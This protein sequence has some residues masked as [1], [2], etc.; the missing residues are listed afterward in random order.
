MHPVFGSWFLVIQL[1]GSAGQRADTWVRPYTVMAG[2]ACRMGVPVAQLVRVPREG[3]GLTP[4]K[5]TAA[6]YTSYPYEGYWYGEQPTLIAI[7]VG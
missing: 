4:T 3:R 7:C 2:L 6:L 1:L 5:T